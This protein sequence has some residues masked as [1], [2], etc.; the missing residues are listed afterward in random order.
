MKI[1]KYS[2][3]VI[4]NYQFALDG[5]AMF[6]I[7][8]KPLW[9]NNNPSDELNRIKLVDRNLLLISDTKKILIDT[10][11][12]NYWDEKFKR[13]YDL[14]ENE[15]KNSL[16]GLKIEP[17]EITDVIL[18]HLHFDHTGGSTKFENDKW[19]PAYPNAKY[20]IQQ[21]HFEWA[22]NPSERDKGSFIKERFLP[23]AK[24]G[25]LVQTNETEFDDEI[26]FIV[27]NGHTFSQQLVK[28]SDGNKTILFCGDLIPYVTQIPIPYIMS[29]DLQPLITI[30]EKKNVLNKAVEE[31][32]LLI[33]E[34][35]PYFTASTVSKNDKGFFAQNKF[36]ELPNE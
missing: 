13:I 21:K 34:H 22:I 6:G 30:E 19:L 29:Y 32:W 14:K 25:L 15:T 17:N 3:H 18:T 33:F 35:D 23:L 16:A 12:G 28:I 26:S 8:P 11:I 7:I 24:E 27:V 2:L 1:G 20:Y 36:I 4:E 9:Q 10:G 5:G 31:N